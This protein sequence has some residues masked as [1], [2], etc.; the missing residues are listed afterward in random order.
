[1]NL[2]KEQL[3]RKIDAYDFAILELKLYLDTHPNDTNALLQRQKLQ[4]VRRELI[5][6]YEKKYGN[7]IVRSTHVKGNRW[8]W[9]DSPWPWEYKG[10]E[11]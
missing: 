11:V 4:G 5:G 9:V 10:K 7:Y 8:S 2:S 1:M 3:L 6:E